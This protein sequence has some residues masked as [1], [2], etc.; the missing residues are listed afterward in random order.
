MS[1]DLARLYQFDFLEPGDGG[2]K[3]SHSGAACFCEQL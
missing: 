2:A 3:V 1:E